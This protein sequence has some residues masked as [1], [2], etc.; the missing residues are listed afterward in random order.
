MKLFFFAIVIFVVLCSQVEGKLVI[1]KV[2]VQYDKSRL[3]VQYL[4]RYHNDTEKTYV[5]VDV[6]SLTDADDIM[7]RFRYC[8]W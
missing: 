2:D 4:L 7:V 1:E 5:S 8:R 3:D 6:Y